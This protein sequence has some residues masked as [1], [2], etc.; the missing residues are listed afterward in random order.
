[1]RPRGTQ[2][3]VATG[4]V[5]ILILATTGGPLRGRLASLPERLNLYIKNYVK[6]TAEEH[7]HSRRAARDETPRH[8]P[9]KRWL[10]SAPVDQR[11]DCP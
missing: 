8:H 6:L 5:A 7:K 11:A 3:Y 2:F 1:M 10:S 9:R 4:L